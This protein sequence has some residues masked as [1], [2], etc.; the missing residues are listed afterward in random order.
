MGILLLVIS[1]YNFSIEI[2][3]NMFDV[4]YNI[5][6]YFHFS[7]S[8]VYNTCNRVLDCVRKTFFANQVTYIMKSCD[9]NISIPT[10][11]LVTTV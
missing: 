5:L 10:L 2:K 7:F 6:N 9:S 4:V 11:N 3:V 1:T 8:V